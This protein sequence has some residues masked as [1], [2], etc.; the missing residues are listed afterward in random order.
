M[1]ILIAG[2]GSIGQRHARNLRAVLGESVELLAYRVRGLPHVISEHMTIEAG[3]V[4]DK[5]GIRSF[6]CLD[7]ALDQRPLATLVCNP[8]S[9][10]VAVAY[11]ALSAGSHVFIEKPL[12]DVWDGVDEL[13]DLAERSRLV[14]TVG[15]QMRF[16]PALLR[17]RDALCRNAI[18]QIVS[19]KA[20]WH[21]YLP[22]AHPY[23]DYRQSYAAR[24][25]LGGGVLRCFIHEFDYLF[26]L[27][28]LPRRVTTI[29]GRLGHL[30][31]D[32]EDTAQTQLEY[33]HAGRTVMVDLDLSFA[34]RERR[35]TLDV[36]G[37]NG[38]VSADF[39]AAITGF[40]RNHL[41][42]GELKH[43]LSAIDGV[44]APAV[45]LR[46]AA[47]SLRM[48]LAARQSLAAGRTITLQ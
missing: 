14:A 25:E 4:E 26:W 20:V 34:T 45:P 7:A 30:D 16:H 3:P 32:V 46:H 8:S 47:Q 5:Y 11:A 19:V 42:V 37:E 41:F 33:H 21:E 1:K 31:I 9:D 13:I 17:V 27:F 15:Y 29:G 6:D 35:R 2:L 24:A 38:T 43:F 48:A 12:S 23:E 22:D 40:E 10:H 28:G 18:G 36:V 44:H 39:N